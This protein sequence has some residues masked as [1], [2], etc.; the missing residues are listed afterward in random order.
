MRYLALVIVCVG[1][2]IAR[3]GDA[4]RGKPNIVF[5]LADDM[6]YGDPHCFNPQ[7]KCPTPNIDRLA[8][9]GM[10]FI[11]A[12][13][14]GPVCVP[15]RYGLLTGRYPF[16]NELDTN[17]RAIIESGRMTIASLLKQHDYSTAMVGKWHQGFDGGSKFDYSKPIRGG[18]V[19]RGFDSFFGLHASLDIPPYF[20]IENDHAVA[21]PTKDVAASNTPGWSPIQGAFWRAGKIAP[22]FTHEDTLP[23]LTRK[24]VEVIESQH[25]KASGKPFF[26]YFAMIAPHTPWVPLEQFK[27][28]SGAGLYGD[29][30]M[31]VD[32]CVGKVLAT[33]DRMGLSDNTLVFFSSDNGPVW[34]PEDVKKFGH[35]AAGGL[36]GMKFDP[37]EGGHR[38]PFIAKW[39]GKV[40]AGSTCD[41]TICFTDMLA[42][43]AAIQGDAHLPKGAGEDSYHILPLLLG[44]DSPRPLRDML[45]IGQA[46]KA[47]NI[48][49]GDWKLIPYRGGGN[50]KKEK[51]D[52]KSPAGQLFNLAN[53]PAEQHNLY[54]QE[55][56]TVARLAGL[57]KKAEEQDHTRLGYAE[58]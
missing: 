2:S 58:K 37:W 44:Q 23:Q 45:V 33:L 49:Q 17:Q 4:P 54:D 40:K 48:R 42:T 30:V 7:S 41:Q 24:A 57:L 26:L 46:K 13:A 1:A 31:E 36:R 6:G 9:D 3:A 14:P 15:S 19:D 35:D 27:G 52:P 22:G 16:R 12:H 21:A 34:F 50:L 51:V 28:K 55:P 47:L 38:M 25:A 56:Q 8:S 11:D 53:D 18:P 43:F 5:I 29:Y 20:F 39:P 32:D 10:R